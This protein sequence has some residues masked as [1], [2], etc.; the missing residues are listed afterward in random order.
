V[1][2]HVEPAFAVISSESGRESQ[3]GRAAL[4]PLLDSATF[5]GSFVW[6]LYFGP[7]VKT[8]VLNFSYE[9]GGP[10]SEIPAAPNSNGWP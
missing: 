10:R 3:S 9:V 8:Y 4:E 1:L 7:G 6:D 5:P 2:A